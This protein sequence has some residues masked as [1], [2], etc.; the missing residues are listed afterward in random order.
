MTTRISSIMI[1]LNFAGSAFGGR[2]AWGRAASHFGALAVAQFGAAALSLVF[3]PLGPLMARV[4]NDPAAPLVVVND[5]TAFVRISRALSHGV[6]TFQGALSWQVAGSTVTV[7]WLVCWN[8][9]R[10]GLTEWG[11]AGS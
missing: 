11:K 1:Q 6:G 5:R 8:F 9:S 2:P 7:S 10:S 3:T 4:G